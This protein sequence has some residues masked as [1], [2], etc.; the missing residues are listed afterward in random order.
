MDRSFLDESPVIDPKRTTIHT[1]GQPEVV[2]GN[3]NHSLYLR[4]VK[5]FTH[6]HCLTLYT[7]H[8]LRKLRAMDGEASAQK[9]DDSDYGSELESDEEVSL[10]ELLQQ[11]PA[12]HGTTLPLLLR[13]IEDH[14]GPKS[15]RRPRA[16]GRKRRGKRFIKSRHLPEKGSTERLTETIEGYR[17]VS[18]PGKS[19]GGSQT[20]LTDDEAYSRK[21]RKPCR[22]S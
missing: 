17:S 21:S 20:V 7:R 1:S 12:K 8:V 18:A 19:T 2:I 5:Y 3:P 13:D 15:S 6:S 10:T 22:K 4:T 14:D 9:I 16:Q 11:A